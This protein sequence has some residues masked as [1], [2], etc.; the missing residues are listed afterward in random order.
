MT[1]FYI[2]RHGETR[3][4]TMGFKQ[5]QVDAEPSQLDENGINKLKSCMIILILVLRTV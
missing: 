3:G 5:G 2:V 4:N 1:E